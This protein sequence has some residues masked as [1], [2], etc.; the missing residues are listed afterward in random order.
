MNN[1]EIIGREARLISSFGT[2]S[3]VP[4]LKIK[5]WNFTGATEF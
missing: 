4:S 1:V 5:A 2:T 3:T